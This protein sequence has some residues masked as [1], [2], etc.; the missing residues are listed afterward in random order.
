MLVEIVGPDALPVDGAIMLVEY[1]AHRC[2]RRI[3]LLGDS[4][5]LLQ[6]GDRE[7]D[8]QAM[9]IN[10]LKLVGRAVRIE[11]AL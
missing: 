11:I 8:A 7:L 9:H 1:G 6:S 4:K 5:I 10:E 3:R 2:L